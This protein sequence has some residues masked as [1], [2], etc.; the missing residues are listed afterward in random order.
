MISELSDEWPEGAVH[1]AGLQ[2][3]GAASPRPAGGSLRG[4]LS[5]R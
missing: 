3:E 4:G 2:A 1:K 5:E